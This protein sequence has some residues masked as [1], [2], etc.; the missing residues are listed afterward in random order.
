MKSLIFISILALSLSASD[1]EVLS[2]LKQNIIELQ[3]KTK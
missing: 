1:V 2:D 3:K